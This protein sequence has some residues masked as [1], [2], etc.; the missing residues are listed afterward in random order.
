M[1]VYY[2]MSVSGSYCFN[3]AAQPDE[4]SLYSKLLSEMG[5]S[6]ENIAQNLKLH[7]V[8]VIDV[9][10]GSGRIILNFGVCPGQIQCVERIRPGVLV[11]EAGFNDLSKYNSIWYRNGNIFTKHCKP[12]NK[13]HAAPYTLERTFVDRKMITSLLCNKRRAVIVFFKH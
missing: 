1:H 6:N 2:I 11:E 5:M 7:H 4:Y 9:C 8:E 12:T 13:Q 10:D 3:V